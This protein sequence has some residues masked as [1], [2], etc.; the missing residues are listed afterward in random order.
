MAKQKFSVQRQT[1]PTVTDA[2]NNLLGI[3]DNHRFTDI[4]LFLLDEIEEQPFP[5]NESKIQQIADSIENVGVIEPL[6]VV[7]NGDRYKIL[8]GRHRF[9][10]CQKLG[11]TEVPCYIKDVSEDIARYILIATNTDRN[12]EYAPSVYARAY[13]EQVELM[14]KLGKKT[15]SAIAE[16]NGINRKQ[17]YRYVRLTYLND[18]LMQWVDNGSIAFLT[19]VELSYLSAEQQNMILAYMNNERLPEK[20]MSLEAAQRL[21]KVIDRYNGHPEAFK[22]DIAKI[23]LN[24]PQKYEADEYPSENKNDETE[25]ENITDEDFS[26]DMNSS[27]IDYETVA[28]KDTKQT[29]PASKSDKKHDFEEVVKGYMLL[30]LKSFGISESEIS[31]SQLDYIFVNNSKSQAKEIYRKKKI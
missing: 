23:L 30:A 22:N 19:G 26:D 1:L 28:K 8:S 4:S 12:N 5:I 15:V 3:Q 16:Q 21:H 27:N 9:R 18:E 29:E 14:K 25:Q 13:A 10:A 17:I 2:Y 20:T 7:K 31:E 6:I 24:I 11:K